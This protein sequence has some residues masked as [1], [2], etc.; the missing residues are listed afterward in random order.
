MCCL[1]GWD[2]TFIVATG[3]VP[4]CAGSPFGNACEHCLHTARCCSNRVSA[5]RAQTKTVIVSTDAVLA[6]KMHWRDL[7]E[8]IQ[9]C[10]YFLDTAPCK[11]PWPLTGA[12][13]AQ[14]RKDV[15]NE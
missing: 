15:S 4:A 10:V 7:L 5:Y 12:V 3:T 11:P 1:R 8:A 2:Q 14:Q 9:R 13:L 6:E